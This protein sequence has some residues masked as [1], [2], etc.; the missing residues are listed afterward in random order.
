MSAENS[1][2]TYRG[3]NLR[4]LQQGDIFTTSGVIR[5]ALTSDPFTPPAW[6]DFDHVRNKLDAPTPLAPGLE[7]VGGRALVMVLSHDCHLDKEINIAAR[8]LLKA[9]RNLSE[10]DAYTEAE[11][12]GTLDRFV[13]VSPLVDIDL[14]PVARNQN[15]RA[16]LLAGRTVSYFPL[17]TDLDPATDQSHR[18]GKVASSIR[19]RTH[20]L[21]LHPRPE[22]RSRRCRG[23]EDC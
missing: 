21:T 14:V 18:S 3:D 7:S 17:P 1:R 8:A 23:S 4:P 9:D 5:L 11:N 15:A 2:D 19:P 12:D 6:I 10:N 13:I 20:G 16:D 22:L